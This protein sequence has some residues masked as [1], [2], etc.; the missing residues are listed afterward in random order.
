M[1]HEANGR[2]F[3]AFTATAHVRCFRWYFFTNVTFPVGL[4]SGLSLVQFSVP[5]D[6]SGG[7]VDITLVLLLT[8]AAYKQLA[9][10]MVP[11]VDYMTKLDKYIMANFVLCALNVVAAGTL[12]HAAEE[13]VEDVSGRPVADL[14]VLGVLSTVWLLIQPCYTVSMHIAWRRRIAAHAGHAEGRGHGEEG[15]N[16]EGGSQGEGGCHEEGEDV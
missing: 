15:G 9:A 6:E 16:G 11:Q 5:P 2:V 13:D 8:L 1:L 4:I 3:S 7:R 14:A 10:Q 12:L